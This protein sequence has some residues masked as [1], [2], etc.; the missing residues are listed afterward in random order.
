MEVQT[1]GC[2]VVSVA[3][4]FLCYRLLC[5]TRLAVCGGRVRDRRTTGCARSDVTGADRRWCDRLLM[6]A[7]RESLLEV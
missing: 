4:M 6:Q 1:T 2:Q 7:P 3:E 5:D